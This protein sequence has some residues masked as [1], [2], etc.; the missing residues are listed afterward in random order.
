MET[1]LIDR[2]YEKRYK[3]ALGWMR[4]VYPTLTGAAKE[5]AE[6][7]FPELAE[8]EDERIR[9]MCI[10]AVNIAASAEGGL[11][12]SE[13]SECLAWLEE[14]K[15]KNCL[16]CDQHLKGYIAG[17]KV[18][19]E[20]KQKENPK[21]ADSISADCASNAKCEDRWHKVQ[22]S[23]PDNPREVLCKDAIG[24]YFLG[25]Y[26]GGEEDYWYVE[27][28]DD[29]D[30]T[31][32]N[33]PPV[34]MWVDIP[35]EKQKEQN[36]ITP[37]MMDMAASECIYGQ[38]GDNRFWIIEKAK[39]DII[40][41]TNIESSP[42]E[43]KVLDNILF[44]AWQMGWLNKYEETPKDPF[45][46]EQFKRGYEAGYEDAVRVNKQQHSDD[47]KNG[48]ESGKIVGRQEQMPTTKFKKGDWVVY[49][50]IL[51]RGILQV[52][53]VKNGRYTFVDNDSTLLAEDSDDCLRPLTPDDLKEQKPQDVK[54]TTSDSSASGKE[55]LYVS[56]KSYN[57]GFRDG[58][59]SV[60]DTPR[61]RRIKEGE[62]LPCP[63]YLWSITYK[64][65]ADHWEGKLIPNMEGVLVGSDTWYLPVADVKN[66]PKEDEK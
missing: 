37:Q 33:N 48:Y 13:A 50:G 35:S 14:Q 52:A 63:A 66:L 41:K 22:D 21:N 39:K 23:L 58:V 9:K 49:D 12:H 61:W 54:V 2:T 40:E 15:D 57:I 42:D 16:A 64:D 18:T 8:S 47:W 36:P 26:F 62:R 55:L 11:L 56:N 59:A 29:A 19:E 65:Y 20:E 1:Y 34:V 6:H 28:Y 45:D 3:N 4:D 53:D 46:D 51:G 43:M 27:V 17:R 10:G 31:N 38:C 30:K 5:D 32:K 44:R 60:K 24:N 7:F 25:R